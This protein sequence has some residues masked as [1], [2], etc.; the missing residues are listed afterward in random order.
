MAL[1]RRFLRGWRILPFRWTRLGL[2][3]TQLGEVLRRRRSHL[4][5]RGPRLTAR[6]VRA[7]LARRPPALARRIRAQAAASLGHRAA[8][9]LLVSCNGQRGL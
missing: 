2:C 8:A 6:L 7:E 4:L 9:T 3:R 1:L 5:R